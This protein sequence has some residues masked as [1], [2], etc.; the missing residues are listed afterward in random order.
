MGH[1]IFE[2]FQDFHVQ[3]LFSTHLAESS[4]FW[5]YLFT[6][7]VRFSILRRIKHFLLMWR[8]HLSLFDIL[9]FEANIVLACTSSIWSLTCYSHKLILIL[10]L[11]IGLADQHGWWHGSCWHSLVIFPLF[12]H[13]QVVFLMLI[14]IKPR[15]ILALFCFG[16]VLICFIII[17]EIIGILSSLLVGISRI[18][19][20]GHLGW[21]LFFSLQLCFF[22][23]CQQKWVWSLPQMVVLWVMIL[24]I[25]VGGQVQMEIILNWQFWILSTLRQNLIFSCQWSFPRF[26]IW[27]D[28]VSICRLVPPIDLKLIP[29]PG[30][31]LVRHDFAISGPGRTSL[32]VSIFHPRLALSC[33]HLILIWLLL[34]HFWNF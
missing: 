4:V 12:L 9:I 20:F 5:L 23:I 24:F 18:L 6:I 26:V 11:R 17:F 31:L 2:I 28:M 34:L 14:H 21:P 13:F 16:L 30:I 3:R 10:N 29:H 8:E 25:L 1:R 22:G 27:P 33:F 7:K 32:L 15:I 19:V